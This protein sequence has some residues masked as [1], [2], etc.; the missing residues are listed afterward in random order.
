[1]LYQK[2]DRR[3][4]RKTYLVNSIVLRLVLNKHVTTIANHT[5]ERCHS[6]PSSLLYEERVNIVLQPKTD[7]FTR[8]LLTSGCTC[9]YMKF[10]VT[11]QVYFR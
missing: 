1:M 2:G 3:R 9:V 5:A 8:T 4:S 7:A 11:F 10:E 6:H